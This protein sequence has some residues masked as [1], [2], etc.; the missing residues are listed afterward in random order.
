MKKIENVALSLRVPADVY[1]A[2]DE[3]AK[4]KGIGITDAIMQ[5]IYGQLI[6]AETTKKAIRER[7]EAELELMEIVRDHASRL[8]SPTIDPHATLHLFDMLQVEHNDLYTRALGP[9]KEQVLRLNPLIARRFAIAIGAIQAV[10]NGRKL[11]VTLPRNA[12]KLIQTYSI[13]KEKG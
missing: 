12:N 1:S 6:N 8:K 5:A 4:G 2:L 13:L 7:M 11:I 9:N 3:H 10:E